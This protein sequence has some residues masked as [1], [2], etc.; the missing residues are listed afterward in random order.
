MSG[1]PLLPLLDF[2]WNARHCQMVWSKWTDRGDACLVCDLAWSNILSLIA[3]LFPWR[4]FTAALLS[5]LLVWCLFLLLPVEREGH[6]FAICRSSSMH[7]FSSETFSICC[8]LCSEFMLLCTARAR[9]DS[10]ASLCASACLLECNRTCLVCVMSVQS[11]L[12]MCC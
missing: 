4:V 5:W 1:T 7:Y 3:S 9:T 10:S 12:Y 6:W 11:N 2:Q 8:V